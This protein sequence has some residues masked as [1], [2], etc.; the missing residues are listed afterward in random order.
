MDLQLDINQGWVVVSLSGRIDSFN[1]DDITSKIQTLV[2]MGKKYLAIDLKEVN[3]LG[4]PS[5]RFLY[6]MAEK[7]ENAQGQLALLSPSEKLLKSIEIMNHPKKFQLAA[8]I[9]ELNLPQ[10]EDQ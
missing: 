4:L 6:Q 2:R 9:A 1:Y 7:L 10:G 3:Y 8:T 5:L